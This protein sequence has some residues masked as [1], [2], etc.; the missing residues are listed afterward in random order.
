MAACN[1]YCLR[2][3]ILR[4]IFFCITELSHTQP[5]QSCLV[6]TVINKLS[7]GEICVASF[8]PRSEWCKSVGSY[9]L[10][11]ILD[12]DLD[13]YLKIIS[14]SLSCSVSVLHNNFILLENELGT[15]ALV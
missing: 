10:I 7:R 2:R 11:F 13:F 5:N 8:T 12:L 1:T 9:F 14:F 6:K 3:L 15:F 4:R